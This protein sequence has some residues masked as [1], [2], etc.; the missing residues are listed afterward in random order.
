VIDFNAANLTPCYNIYSHLI[1]AV[2]AT[3][4]KYTMINGRM[5]MAERELLTLEEDR[6]RKTV[7]Q[8]AERIRL[9]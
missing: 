6:V 4:V 7:C 8:L 3:D 9:L 2:S 5:V 1:Y